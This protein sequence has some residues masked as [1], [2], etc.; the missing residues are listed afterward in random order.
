MSTHPLPTSTEAPAPVKMSFLDRY[1]TVWI[2]AA[3][4]IGVLIGAVFPQVSHWNEAMSVGNTN[5]PLAIGLILMMYP[6]LAKVDYSLLKSVT[7][8][9]QAMTLSLVM[10]WIVG[11]IL[12]FV[13]AL[14]FLGDHPGYM[15]GIILIG[16]ARCIAMVLVWNDI[17][18]GN[19]EYGA[20][21]VALNS[22][23]QIITYS[24]MA[25]L[26]IS[27]L[28]P[29]FGYQGFA[30]DISML[31]IAHSV[32]IY[33]GVPFAAGFLSR[34]YLVKFKGQDWYNQVFIPKISPITLIALLGT[35]ILMF[36]LKGEMILELPMDVVRI[37]IPLA[38]Y[39]VVMFFM[40][41]F[42]GKKMGI[43][44]DKNASIAFTATGNNFELAIAVS[45]AVFGLNS[46][47]A[48]AGVIG[49]L[50]E[51]PVLIGLVNLALRMK[52]KYNLK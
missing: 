6:P 5:I 19:K 8:D 32:L 41:F 15:V 13:L 26:F 28:P 44:Y 36:S 42:I 9:R 50:I 23:F 31:D 51:V 16:L 38:I 34:K 45:I 49:P 21:L 18:G 14:T 30:I 47:Q 3:M 20:T 7:K 11:P 48:F 37:A 4:A 33:L 39:F 17:G 29:Y 43:S 25:W 12:M 24:F 27:V 1:L 10:N 22:A 2:F 46:D 52:Q 40:S 35:I